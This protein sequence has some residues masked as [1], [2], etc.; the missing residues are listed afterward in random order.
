[1]SSP[2]ARMVPRRP[3]EKP[4]PTFETRTAERIRHD[5]AAAA[6]EAQSA[7]TQIASLNGRTRDI[8]R[9]G[10]DAAH[11]RHE[12]EIA[13][14]GRVIARAEQRHED[15]TVELRTAEASEAAAER[16]TQ[17]ATAEAAV[18]A[19]ID[20]AAA[21]YSAPA[22]T[23]AGFLT[24][25]TEAERLAREAGIPGPAIVSGRDARRPTAD[26]AERVESWEAYADEAGNPTS[27][28]HPYKPDGS[29]DRTRTREWRT[30]RRTVPV[31]AYA[32]GGHTRPALRE[33]V[34][35][36]QLAEDGWHHG[37]GINNRATRL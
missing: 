36:P 10:D 15:L 25:W 1:M 26:P 12:T 2:V 3:A 11:E 27:N 23:I 14:L 21:E 20:R 31:T 5:V 8:L 35:L 22:A 24:D 4:G 29:L 33:T 16:A 6:S 17:R 9:T 13:R 32:A 18:A 28:P 34:R 30:F 7:A 19:V 37:D